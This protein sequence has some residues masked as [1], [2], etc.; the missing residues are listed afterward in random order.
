MWKHD[1]L[2]WVAK[3]PYQVN[4]ELLQ[5]NDAFI[6]PDSRSFTPFV[7]YVPYKDEEGDFKL[8][9]HKPS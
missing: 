3:L 8:E 6:E 5:K 9:G 7:I 1:T 2:V 4:N